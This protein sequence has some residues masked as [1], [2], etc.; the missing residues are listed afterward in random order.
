MHFYRTGGHSRAILYR[1]WCLV[2]LSIQQAYVTNSMF[3]Q[4]TGL[5]DEAEALTARLM[6]FGGPYRDAAKGL[7]REIRT[8]RFAKTGMLGMG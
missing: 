4:D 5:Y 1:S 8:A 6:D 7:M 3:W 2:E